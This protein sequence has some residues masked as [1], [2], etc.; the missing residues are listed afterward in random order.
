MFDTAIFYDLGV[1]F[2]INHNFK[3]QGFWFRLTHFFGGQTNFSRFGR[4]FK[5]NDFSIGAFLKIMV[6]FFDQDCYFLKV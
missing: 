1:L 6:L 2:K 3:D 5:D 4:F